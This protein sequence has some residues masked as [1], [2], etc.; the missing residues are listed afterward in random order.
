MRPDA[1][2]ASTIRSTKGSL[3]GRGLV[4][5]RNDRPSARFCKE[6]CSPASAA[7][8]SMPELRKASA[9]ASPTRRLAASSALISGTSISA[10]RGSP[11][12]DCTTTRPSASACAAPWCESATKPGD[13][14]HLARRLKWG[15]AGF[16]WHLDLEGKNLNLTLTSTDYGDKLRIRLSFPAH[17]LSCLVH[18]FAL[19]TCNEAFPLFRWRAAPRPS[20]RMLR[21]PAG[22]AACGAAA[23]PRPTTAD[24]QS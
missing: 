2:L 18:S 13:L 12:A 4:R 21:R 3:T 5:R 15:R 23:R 19:L 14:S 1:Q 6:I 10:R 17:R 9:E 7:F 24:H 11:S 20:R 16:E 22:F 8:I